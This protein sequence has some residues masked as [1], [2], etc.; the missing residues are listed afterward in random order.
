MRTMRVLHVNNQASVGYLLS[1]A[2]RKLGHRSDLLSVPNPKQRP[3]DIGAGSVP[4]LFAELLA[5][6]PSYDIIHVHGGIGISGL[7]LWPY[8]LAGKRFFCHYHGSE[9]REGKQTL[10]HSLAERL[11]I[12][13]PDLKRFSGNVGGRELVHI[14]NPVLV[15]RVTPVDWTG[16]SGE[17]EGEGPMRIAHLP[18]LRRVKGTDNVIAGVKEACSNGARFELDVIE[19]VTLDDAMKRLSKAHICIDWMSDDYDIHGVVSVE[20]MVRAVPVV[21]N[22]DRSL[23]PDD[24]PI[25][26][27]KPSSLAKVLAELWDKRADLPSIGER[28]RRYALDRHDPDRV[29]QLMEKYI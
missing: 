16:R 21:C 7:G 1:R 8:R 24:I 27:S 18:S 11:F 20:A 4:W 15:D 23:Y 10:F 22:I 28:S 17:L 2:Q 29:A 14:P 12:S 13:T 3:P 19:D 26:A 9:L 6:A 25:V 5:K